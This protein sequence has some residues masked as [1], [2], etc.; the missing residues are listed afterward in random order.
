MKSINLAISFLV[1]LFLTI[2]FTAC[3]NETSLESCI[4][5]LEYGSDKS[6]T[7]ASYQSIIDLADGACKT[8][9]ENNGMS[10]ELK[11]YKASAY[12]GKA[13][14]SLSSLIDTLLS[15]GD[16]MTELMSM[17]SGGTSA[18]YATEAMTLYDDISNNTA[19]SNSTRADATTITT[20]VRPLQAVGAI[21]TLTGPSLTYNGEEVSSLTALL[22]PSS[23]GI[24]SGSYTEFDVDGNGL[25]DSTQATAIAMA[26]SVSNATTE[27]FNDATPTTLAFV[28]SG[29]TYTYNHKLITILS[30]DNATYNNYESYQ[31][32]DQSTS[33]P[34]LTDGYCN[35]T[36][37]TCT[38]LNTTDCFVCPIISSN[39]TA[40]TSTTAV[41]DTLNA[42]DSTSP[43][44]AIKTMLDTNG[45]GLTE[46]ELATYLSTIN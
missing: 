43:L 8:V 3:G 24:V 29:T 31:L 13:G 42:I 15:G 34:V 26:G 2:S 32:L 28:K 36:F 46:A 25:L 11:T 16:P 4:Y 1:I 39:G 18:L 12:M 21:S 33:V 10:C 6:T 35:L 40:L 23:V 22:N 37:T 9:L 44:Y 20:Y 14:I 41:V 19:C 38:T 7:Q 5:K 45:D 27:S 30:G 17:V